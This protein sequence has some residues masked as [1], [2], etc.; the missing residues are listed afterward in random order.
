MLSGGAK[1]ELGESGSTS[2]ENGGDS[3]DDDCALSV[4]APRSIPTKGGGDSGEKGGDS[5]DSGEKGGDSGGKGGVD[6]GSYGWVRPGETV[7]ALSDQVG[8]PGVT[9]GDCLRHGLNVVHLGC[10][11][12]DPLPRLL[13]RPRFLLSLLIIC[14]VPACLSVSCRLRDG[15]D[16]ANRS[17]K[18]GSASVSIDVGDWV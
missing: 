6:W 9:G 8:L 10:S 13:S 11:V 5:G 16:E 14:H 18:D 17:G 15:K 4:D 7:A 12:P 3:L 1:E 2:G